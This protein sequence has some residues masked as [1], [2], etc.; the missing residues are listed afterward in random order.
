MSNYEIE[1]MTRQKET[2][3]NNHYLQIVQKLEN[4]NVSFEK[5]ELYLTQTILKHVVEAPSDPP[6]T[7]EIHKEGLTT[8]FTVSMHKF[9][10][11]TLKAEYY[12]DPRILS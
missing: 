4:L 6:K 10:L 11:Q 1:R 5:I 3:L 12:F 9:L 7:S 2:D 8:R